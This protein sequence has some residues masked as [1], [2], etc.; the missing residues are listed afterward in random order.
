MNLEDLGKNLLVLAMFATV[1]LISH[2]F[3]DIPF[4]IPLVIVCGIIAVI[5]IIMSEIFEKIFGDSFL[6]KWIFSFSVISISLFIA[7]LK[8]DIPILLTLAKISTFIDAISICIKIA[9][10]ILDPY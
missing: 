3:L 2:F 6:A 10:K 4:M 9:I 1:F 8:L 7:N 5:F